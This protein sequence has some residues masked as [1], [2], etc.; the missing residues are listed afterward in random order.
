MSLLNAARPEQQKISI[1]KSYRKSPSLKDQVTYRTLNK[2]RVLKCGN[3]S[4]FCGYLHEGESLRLKSGIIVTC[5]GNFECTSR[6]IICI[7]TCGG[8]QESYLGETGDELQ[9]RWVVHRQ[10][11]KMERRQAPAQADVHLRLCGKGNYTVFP[12]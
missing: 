6:N 11:S 3:N 1:I 2:R 12:Y 4:K 9:S 10:Q 7:A 8:C 5:N